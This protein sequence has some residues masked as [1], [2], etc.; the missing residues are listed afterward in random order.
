MPVLALLLLLSGWAHADV[1][2]DPPECADG[3]RG[4]SSHCGEW[5]V[6]WTCETD[7]QCSGGTECIEAGQCI[8]DVSGSCSTAYD[9]E[10]YDWDVPHGPCE[11]D[12]DCSVGTCVVTSYCLTPPAETEDSAPTGGDSSDDGDE[13]DDG[14]KSD[15]CLGC[16]SA[17]LSGSWSS[18]AS[19]AGVVGLGVLLLVAARRKDE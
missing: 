7:D 2:Y 17:R 18:L 1:V 11:T 12:D 9:L 8:E 19:S 10:T 15:G 6:A 4:V 14:D 16:A 5:C 3:S 13:S